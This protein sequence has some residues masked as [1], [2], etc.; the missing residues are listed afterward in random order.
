[1]VQVGTVEIEIGEWGTYIGGDIF[2]VG[3][4]RTNLLLKVE[5]GVYG[6]QVA[7]YEQGNITQKVTDW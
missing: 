5:R 1:M 2:C 6:H 4:R 3:M 7:K